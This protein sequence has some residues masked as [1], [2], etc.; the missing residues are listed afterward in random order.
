VTTGTSVNL[1]ADGGVIIERIVVSV[2]G[3]VY[4][5]C[6]REEFQQARLDAREPI[7]IGFKKEYLIGSCPVTGR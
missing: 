2:D 5:V 7:C 1:I 6:K 3:D 4:F